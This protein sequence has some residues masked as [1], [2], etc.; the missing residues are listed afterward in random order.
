MK[1]K[2]VDSL[3]QLPPQALT[4]KVMDGVFVTPTVPENSTFH[5]TPKLSDVDVEP[6]RLYLQN[7]LD[8]VVV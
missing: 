1:T 8:H 5:F 3:S 6:K 2:R 7:I 4:R